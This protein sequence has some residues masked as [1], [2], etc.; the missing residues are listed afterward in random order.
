MGVF[1]CLLEMALLFFQIQTAAAAICFFPLDRPAMAYFRK[2]TTSFPSWACFRACCRWPC[3]IG[4]N[5]NSSRNLFF[6]AI[7][8]GAGYFRSTTSFPS[9]KQIWSDFRRGICIFRVLNP[10]RA[11]EP[12]PMLNPSNFVPK[13]GFPVVKGLRA[14]S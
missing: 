8:A 11:P 4:L 1:S 7:P 2:S 14:S 10:F 5:T 6:S 9:P 3:Y 13:N 12:L